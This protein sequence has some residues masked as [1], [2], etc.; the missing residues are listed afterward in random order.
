MDGMSFTVAT[1][2][3]TLVMALSIPIMVARIYVWCFNR[4]ED[5]FRQ[6]HMKMIL[7]NIRKLEAI[8]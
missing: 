5:Y 6:R 4:L 8:K 3:A 1:W 2:M 7:E